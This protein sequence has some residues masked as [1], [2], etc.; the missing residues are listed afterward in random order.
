MNGFLIK[1]TRGTNK[2]KKSNAIK[3]KEDVTDVKDFSLK[4]PRLRKRVGRAA[5]ILFASLNWTHRKRNEGNNSR[6]I[7]LDRA[8]FAALSKVLEA[9]YI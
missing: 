6:N 3:E 7:A 9:F 5:W 8:L 1:K 2:K 4:G